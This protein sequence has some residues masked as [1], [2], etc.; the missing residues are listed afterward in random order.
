MFL[1]HVWLCV[2]FL[3]LWMMD[4][5]V[6]RAVGDNAVASLQPV[7]VLTLVYLVVRTWLAWRDPKWL[8]WEY[9]FPPLDVLIVSAFL[10]LSHRGP[11]SNISLLYFLPMISAAGSL[12]VRWAAAVG[13]MV[14]V[15]TA[16]ST[17]AAVDFEPVQTYGSAKE[18]LQAEPLNAS[19]RLYFLVVLSSLMAFQALIAAGLKERLAVAADRNRIALDMHDG[20]Q[21]HLI[22]LAQQMELLGHV[23]ERNPAR[24]AE[25]AREGRET[26][27]QAADELRFLVQ[28][29]RAPALEDGFVPALRQYAHNVCTRHGLRLEFDVAGTEEGLDPE[30]ENALFRI[31]QEALTN[32][33]KHAEA[34]HVTLG[35]E[36]GDEVRLLVRD[37]GRGFGPDCAEGVGL[38]GIRHRAQAAGGSA[39]IAC[40]GHGTTVRA[41]VPA[42]DSASLTLRSV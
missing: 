36:F 14:V 12:N 34:S 30:V 27:R 11:M 18:L 16:V 40:E 6:R 24:A 38:E 20:V 8:Q 9:V 33:A 28:R 23:A 42:R 5:R 17:F 19:F 26:A 15:G 4:L 21:G 22:A 35:L 39:S 37:D 29:L 3:V 32:V 13:V 31:A 1:A 7:I 2:P 25:L 10:Y 41:S